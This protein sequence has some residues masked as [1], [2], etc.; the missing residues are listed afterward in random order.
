ML[1]YPTMDT[2]KH[3]GNKIKKIR[4]KANLTQA[5]VADKVGICFKYLVRLERGEANPS[6]LII[7]NIAKALNVKTPDLLPF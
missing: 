6:I 7:Q 1:Y 4:E 3:V 2:K 5:Q